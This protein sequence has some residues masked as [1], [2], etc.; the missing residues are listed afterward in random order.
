MCRLCSHRARPTLS[1][2][3]LL[4]WDDETYPRPVDETDKIVW[5]PGSLK[6][7]HS[8]AETFVRIWPAESDDWGVLNYRPRDRIGG[9]KLCRFSQRQ[10]VD[11]VSS[12]PYNASRNR[13]SIRATTKRHTNCQ[14]RH[15]QDLFLL[16]GLV[17]T[18]LRQVAL[19]IYRPFPNSNPERHFAPSVRPDQEYDIHAE[20]D[21]PDRWIPDLSDGFRMLCPALPGCVI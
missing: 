11:C 5:P 2:T 21:F 10:K 15:T 3:K 17:A 6:K 7:P 16:L 9:G 20:D 8:S 12:P 4:L 19:L 18:V 14:I 13:Q 1:P